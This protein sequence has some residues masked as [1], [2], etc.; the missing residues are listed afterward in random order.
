MTGEDKT[1][2]LELVRSVLSSGELRHFAVDLWRR[3]RIDWSFAGDRLQ[4][5]LRKNRQLNSRTRRWVGDV[6]YGLIRHLRRVDEA[7]KAGGV[8]TTTGAPDE[9]RLMT[10]LMLE[11]P[12]SVQDAVQHSSHLRSARHVDWQAV[13]DI[14]R[15][16]DAERKP[17]RRLALKFSFPDWLA[18]RLVADLGDDAE[19]FAAAVNR[20]GPLCARPNLLVND[21]D[22]LAQAFAAEGITTTRGSFAD[23]ALRVDSQRDV[24]A[25]DSY[26]AG[27]FEL[28]DEASQVVANLAFAPGHSQQDQ[29]KPLLVDYCAGAGGKTLAWA[30]RLGN[31]GRLI[32]CDTDS[33]KLSELK[34]R[35]KRAGV[36]NV[37]TVVLDDTTHKFVDELRGSVRCVLVDAPCSGLGAMRR[38][39]E[40]RWR[41]DPA[42]VKRLSALQ[43][44]ILSTASEL[45]AP[46]GVLLYA[47]C[48][49]LTAENRR[50][51]ET[52]LSRH[53]N[54]T[55]R[56]LTQ[57]WPER[58]K[59]VG[60]ASGDYMFMT[61]H[62]HDTDGFFAA[63]LQRE[64]TSARVEE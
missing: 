16:I 31:R 4:Q 48:T 14:D 11:G 9:L 2:D 12:V 62:R 46:G 40:V 32:A 57:V 49:V 50:V 7:L 5:E 38:H 23:N 28:Q 19:A 64:P 53:R 47:T 39:P 33:R 42:Q 10:Y 8:R 3:T 27:G 45:V 35:A 34:K 29:A 17:W 21:V 52:F 20:R 55:V 30:S 51:V 6:V 63:V 43:A 60:D 24:H 59:L 13:A 1:Q 61:P 18:K 37:R 58:A 54:F 22:Q 26:R 25:L 56:P 15:T 36:T 44:D 41:I